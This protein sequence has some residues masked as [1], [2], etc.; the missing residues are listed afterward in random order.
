[1][2]DFGTVLDDRLLVPNFHA[3]NKLT[4]LA[5]IVRHLAANDLVEDELALLQFLWDHEQRYGAVKHS[6]LAI[7]GGMAITEIVRKV[8]FAVFVAPEGIPYDS[9][10]GLPIR[11]ILVPLIPWHGNA[12]GMKYMLRLMRKIQL[13]FVKRSLLEKAD[14]PSLRA[15]LLRTLEIS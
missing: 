11:I 7:P 3:P 5:G 14:A 2:F 8:I 15:L 1:M 12:L 4:A 6:G 10:D 13:P 9:P